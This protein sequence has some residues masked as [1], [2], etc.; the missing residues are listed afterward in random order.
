MKDVV[1]KSSNI[2]PLPFPLGRKSDGLLEIPTPKK[3]K[4]KVRFTHLCMRQSIGLKPRTVADFSGAYEVYYP[5]VCEQNEAKII[6]F[7]FHSTRPN[8]LVLFI[9]QTIILKTVLPR[10]KSTKYLLE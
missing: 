9:L 6:V 3:I 5:T 4:G 1:V 7:Y 8:K 2:I 10:G